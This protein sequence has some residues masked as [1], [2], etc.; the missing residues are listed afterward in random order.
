MVLCGYYFLVYGADDPSYGELTSPQGGLLA[1]RAVSIFY[2]VRHNGQHH[3]LKPVIGKNHKIKPQWAVLKGTDTHL[4][5]GSYAIGWYEGPRRVWRDCGVNPQDA[6]A[7]AER[8]R[9]YLEAARVGLPIQKE[10]ASLSASLRQ[11]TPISRSISCHEAT[12]PT[13]W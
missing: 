13:I 12:N 4:P 10:E 1:N 7:A 5:G 2:D 8:Q 3:R 9:L 11:F 6:V